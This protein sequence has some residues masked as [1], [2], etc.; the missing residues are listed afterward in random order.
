MTNFVVYAAIEYHHY[1]NHYSGIH[2]IFHCPN[3]YSINNPNI[4]PIVPVVSIFF[5]IINITPTLPYIIPAKAHHSIQGWAEE[6]P[7]VTAFNC[8]Y[9]AEGLNLHQWIPKYLYLYVHIYIHIYSIYFWFYQNSVYLIWSPHGKDDTIL[10][11]IVGNYPISIYVLYIYI[12]TGH[13]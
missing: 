11:S 13:F 8:K 10:G 6:P 5:S 12:Y 9:F 4:I 3:I 2:S 1:I 7:L